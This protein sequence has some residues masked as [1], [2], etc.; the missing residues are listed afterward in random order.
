MEGESSQYHLTADVATLLFQGYLQLP[1]T[2]WT[3]NNCTIPIQSKTCLHFSPG[4]YRFW[5]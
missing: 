1:L 3:P 5:L 2:I 4:P